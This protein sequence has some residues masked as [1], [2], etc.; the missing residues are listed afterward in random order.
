MKTEHWVGRTPDLMRSI[1]QGRYFVPSQQ[2]DWSWSQNQVLDF[3]DSLLRGWP[4]G[5]F[6]FARCGETSATPLTEYKSVTPAEQ[7]VILDGRHRME[8]LYRLAESQEPLT[9]QG[10]IG[11][12]PA[13]ESLPTPVVADIFGALLHGTNPMRTYMARIQA[14]AVDKVSYK[15]LT[16]DELD[17]ISVV[18]AAA[19]RVRDVQHTVMVLHGPPSEYAKVLRRYATAG[20]PWTAKQLKELEQYETIE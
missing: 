4:I 5:N 12:D 17:L 15:S 13:W 11:Q 14:C 20:S 10:L 3:A 18:D 6:I 16:E 1:R 19:N 7:Y 8:S 2:R 9:T